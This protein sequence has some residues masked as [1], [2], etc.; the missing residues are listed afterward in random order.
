MTR[1]ATDLITHLAA[2][3]DSEVS[4][5]VAPDTR[6]NLA[7]RIMATPFE[8]VRRTR[9]RLLVGIPVAVGL[10]AT[11]IAVGSLAAPGSKVG[12]VQVGPSSAQAA[13]LSFSQPQGGYITVRVKDPY[14]DSARYQKEFAAHGMR[15]DL[16]VVP[17]SPSIV[18]TVIA[19]GAGNLPKDKMVYR[20]D[21]TLDKTKTIPEPRPDKRQIIPVISK[22]ACQMSGGGEACII[23]M[24]VP[25]GYRNHEMVVFGRAAR[26]GELYATTGPVTAPGEVM[27]GLAYRGQTVADVLTML[28]KRGVTVV[29]YRADGPARPDGG[30][31]TESLKSVP[32]TWY[33]QDAR[34]YADHQ[35]MLFVSAKPSNS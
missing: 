13:A 17:A 16:S 33:V 8:K 20:P 32:G 4:A 2:V 31:T 25:V 7:E 12:P 18:G 30:V 27:H 11:A 19:D 35:V 10:T 6:H 28:G 15:I 24:K 29:A 3:S 34:P 9:R 14:A 26:P 22:G 5:M 23:G 1:Q 21:G